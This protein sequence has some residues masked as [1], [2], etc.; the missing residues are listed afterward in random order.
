MRKK[1]SWNVKLENQS[2]DR[3]SFR[4]VTCT[5]GYVPIT[6][7]FVTGFILFFRNS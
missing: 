1:K 6:Q 2:F 3:V 4:P 7:T 5:C